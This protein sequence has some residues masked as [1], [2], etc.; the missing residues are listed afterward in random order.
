MQTA[1]GA[2]WMP[3][4]GTGAVAPFGIGRAAGSGP[5]SIVVGGELVADPRMIGVTPLSG[6]PAP[7]ARPPV[8][9]PPS[10]CDVPASG[11]RV[12]VRPIRRAPVRLTRRGRLVLLALLIVL[13]G[14][15][16][17]AVALPSQAA[18]PAGP[19]RVVVVQPGDSLWTIAER[20]RPGVDPVRAMDEL[21]RANGLTGST[22]QPGEQLTLPTDW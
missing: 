5:V 4:Q 19:A 10:G 2:R 3:R 17:A 6:V 14:S 13:V 20:Y 7:P 8:A 1:V 11:G 9:A 21:S 15:L 12:P 16:T 22:L 18:A